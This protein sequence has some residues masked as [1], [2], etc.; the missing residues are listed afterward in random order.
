MS[1]W[2]ALAGRITLFPGPGAVPTAPLASALELY[3]EAWG[4]EPDLLQ[5]SVNALAPTIA[6]GKRA[7][8]TVG[9]AVHPV[10]IDF[11]LTPPAASE[12]AGMTFRL[13]ED[14]RQFH[15][16]LVRLIKFIGAGVVGSASV[17]RV[18]IFLHFVQLAADIQEANKLLTAV[19]PDQYRV[20]ITDE[21]DF[22]FQINRPQA[23]LGVEGVKMNYLVKWS[24]DRFQ[25]FNFAI[26]TGASV[27]GSQSILPPPSHQFIAASVTFD[28]N[29]VPA[30][31]PLVGKQQSSLLSEGLRT[32][33]EMQQSISLGIEGF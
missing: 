30:A 28:H 11:N 5:K 17:N 29:N 22:V 23:S 1:A 27:T 25:V 6:Q 2:R 24:V 32:S 26:P 19:M 3:K 13:I 8:M 4:G 14:T 9:C 15:T 21:E 7:E 31:S 20:R 33:E 12:E 16:E 18:G 10:R